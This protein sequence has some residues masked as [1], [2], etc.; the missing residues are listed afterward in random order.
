VALVGNI[1]G[2]YR[3]ENPRKSIKHQKSMELVMDASHV[4]TRV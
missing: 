4:G 3:R 2:F 1:L